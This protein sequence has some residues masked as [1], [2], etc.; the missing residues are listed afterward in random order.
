MIEVKDL[1]SKWSNILTSGEVRREAV[2]CAVSEVLNTEVKLD[3][4]EIRGGTAYLRL[5]PTYKNEIFLKQEKISERVGE[6]LM[7]ARLP[8]DIR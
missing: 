7:G 4:V 5:R 3:E 2:R 8:L 6:L 1:L